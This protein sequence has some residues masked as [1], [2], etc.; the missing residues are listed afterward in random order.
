LFTADKDIILS[1]AG[2]IS[3]AKTAAVISILIDLIH[4][5]RYTI[6]N[7]FQVSFIKKT[8]F[9]QVMRIMIPPGL[10]IPGL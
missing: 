1:V 5:K 3:D 7:T 6:S 8:T 9:L 4:K 2:H 10:T